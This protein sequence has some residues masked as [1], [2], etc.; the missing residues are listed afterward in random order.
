MFQPLI[1]IYRRGN[2]LYHHWGF[3]SIWGGGGALIICHGYYRNF[4]HISKQTRN[5][6]CLK[7][8]NI[9]ITSP[10]CQR[11]LPLKTERCRLK[12]KKSK[13]SAQFDDLKI[14]SNNQ[15]CSNFDVLSKCKTKNFS[16]SLP[17]AEKGLHSSSSYQ[18]H[19]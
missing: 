13:T 18:S 6:P 11:Y 12:P 4:I 7:I 3:A 9:E 15:F 2:F 17:T 16:L 10:P 19:H 5:Y 1:V 14:S 8:R